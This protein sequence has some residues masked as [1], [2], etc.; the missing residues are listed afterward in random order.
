M[1][2]AGKKKIIVFIDDF[3]N[4]AVKLHQPILTTKLENHYKLGRCSY[5]MMII[6]FL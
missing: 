4:T 2:V 5:L 6:P 1:V 3:N